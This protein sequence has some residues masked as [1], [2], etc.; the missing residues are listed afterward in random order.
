MN[1]N[2]IIIKELAEIKNPLL[3]SQVVYR[4]F[5]YLSNNPDLGHNMDELNRLINNNENFAGLFAF[6]SKKKLIGYLVG[7]IKHLSDGRLVYYISYLF[8]NE[9]YR[10]KRIGS[11]LL[12]LIIN[13][14]KSRGYSFIVL[15][16]DTQDQKLINFYKKYG[17][18]YDPILRN[19]SKHDVLSLFL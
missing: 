6:N 12:E 2:K 11:H 13:K 7:E 17:F 14:C 16:C 10:H 4:D 5:Q 3:L 9:K 19:N 1:S 18:N 8:V 15:T